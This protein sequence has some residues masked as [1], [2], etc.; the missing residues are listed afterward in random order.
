MKKLV[1]VFC[2][3]MLLCSMLCTNPVAVNAAVTTSDLAP[4]VTEYPST[5]LEVIPGMEGVTIDSYANNGDYIL[6]FGYKNEDIIN[7][8]CLYLIRVS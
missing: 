5:K 4:T 2:I 7:S 6:A 1:S 8:I 3:L